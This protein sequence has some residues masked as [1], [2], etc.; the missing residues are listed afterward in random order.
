MLGEI[1]RYILNVNLKKYQ[2]QTEHPVIDPKMEILVKILNETVNYFCKK[3]HFR[4]VTG[5]EFASTI[6]QTFYTN[7]NRAILRFF[8]MVTL[9]TQ[10]GFYLYKVNNRNTKNTSARCEMCSKLTVR[11]P[12]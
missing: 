8:E 6:N 3:I 7:K 5:S 1:K 12:E 4:C 9:T 2:R 10:P 11:T